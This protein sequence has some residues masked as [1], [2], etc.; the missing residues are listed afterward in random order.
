MIALAWGTR[1]EFEYALKLNGVLTLVLAVVGLV[2]GLVQYHISSRADFLKP[3]RESQ[4]DL[5]RQASTAAARLS[6][7]PADENE[8]KSAKADF[9]TLYYGPPCDC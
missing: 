1:M 3:I 2:W 8:W 5:Y 6:T 7:L 4:L 9:L